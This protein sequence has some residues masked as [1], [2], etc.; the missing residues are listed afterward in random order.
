[1]GIFEWKDGYVQANGIRIHYYHTGGDKPALVL[2]HGATDDGLCWSML[3]REL[4]PEY[5]VIMLDTRGHGL[6]E[7]GKGDY[8]SAAR[9]ADLSG[10][11]Q[12]LGL[13]R[14]VIGGHSMGADSSLN[15]AIQSPDLVRGI[16]LE[17]PPLVIPGQP[18]FG[19][20]YGANLDRSFNLFTG[21]LRLMKI[22]PVSFGARLARR[23]NPIYPEEDIV[24]WVESKK[25]LS[26]DFLESIEKFYG[27]QPPYDLLNQ[28][29]VPT[30]LL[31]GDREK[32]GIVSKEAAEQ[33]INGRSNVKIAHIAG[34]GH[35][36][37]RFDFEQYI[38]LVREF[39][40]D[41]CYN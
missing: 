4:Q 13:D 6:S 16:F 18:V 23:L 9:A 17:D 32:G 33:A 25:R 3:A 24:P 40:K 20:D 8:S 12:G 38:L 15:L 30:L 11:I 37:R 39:L 1:M 34:A 22:L 10:A 28:V 7:S 27:W 29:E 41:I 31:I 2:S 21:G 35:D 14:P 26:K 19:G 36:V 5:D